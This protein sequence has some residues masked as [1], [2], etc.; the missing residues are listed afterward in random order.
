HRAR[1]SSPTCWGRWREAPEGGAPTGLVR[2]LLAAAMHGGLVDRPVEVVSAED[3]PS[4]PGHADH[5]HQ[6]GEGQPDA[7]GDP[8]ARTEVD[9]HGSIIAGLRAVPLG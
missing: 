9:G 7:R 2:V 1:H 4:P 6:E 3:P 5:R 8:L